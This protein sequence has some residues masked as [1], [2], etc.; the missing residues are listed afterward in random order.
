MEW[1]DNVVNYFT[2]DRNDTVVEERKLENQVSSYNESVENRTYD[3][4]PKVMSYPSDAGGPDMPHTVV[5]HINV[6]SNSSMG[7]QLF[8]QKG[9]DEDWA[10]S[11]QAYQNEY[12]SKESRAKG[13]NA[14]TI[15]GAGAALAAGG[16]AFGT[17][18]GNNPSKLAKALLPLGAGV[19]AGTIV[20]AMTDTTTKYRLDSSISLHIN[21]PPQVNYAADWETAELGPVVGALASGKT[22]IS[23]LVNTET[24][25]LLGRGVIAAA[26]SIPK[27][28]GVDMNVAGAIEATTGKVANPYKEQLFKSMRF[29]EFSFN[30]QFVPRNQQEYLNVQN[31][32]YQFKRH[33]HPEVSG[34]GLFLIYPSEFNIEY[35]YRGS[36]NVHINKIASCAL[37]NMKVTYGG[38]QFNTVRN[39]NGAPAEINL[40][41]EFTELDMLNAQRI[42]DG[43]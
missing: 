36:Q 15:M 25:E 30:Y 18:L 16:A 41:L 33:M 5:F 24:S 42:E 22:S 40:S 3:F 13:E 26:A 32:I 1:I 2:G 14:D 39:T 19:A 29:R 21:N 10:A 35:Y 12:L 34:S 17:Q 27:A 23:G 9:N 20:G 11:Q 28:L 7:K 31:I 37:K 6:R 38:D 4:T 43:L 8:D